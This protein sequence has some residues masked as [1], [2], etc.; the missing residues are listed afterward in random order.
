MN[1]FLMQKDIPVISD[2]WKNEVNKYRLWVIL[3]FVGIV[4]IATLSLISIV[5]RATGMTDAIITKYMNDYNASVAASKAIDFAS[6]KKAYLISMIIW[7]SVLFSLVCF[8]ILLSIITIRQSYK[9]H[10]FGL[11]SWG[12]IFIIQFSAFFALIN[13]MN[14][15]F[16]NKGATM[17]NG[18]PGTIFTMIVM[19]LYIPIWYFANRVSRIRK[20]FILSIRME[21]LKSDPN[22]QN[23]QQQMQQ[24]MSNSNNRSPFGFN[25]RSNNSN[26]NQNNNKPNTNAVKPNKTPS[27]NPNVPV[28]QASNV[29]AA[30]ETDKQLAKLKIGQLR[31]I[32]KKLYI[33][34]YD[35]MSKQELIT[36][37]KKATN[38]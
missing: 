35:I 22:Y 4:T 23:M 29:P 13:V 33:S 32:A 25:P 15:L 8:S 21:K 26:F 12:A 36:S 31:E 28:Q 20:L 10:N 30:S 5:L 3:F 19:F 11:I 16:L 17:M 24:F 14:F 7:P 6:A 1:P 9:Q 27:N 2:L 34:G 38:K 18:N 37:I